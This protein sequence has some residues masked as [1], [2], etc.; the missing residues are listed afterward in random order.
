MDCRQPASPPTVPASCHRCD[1]RLPDHQQHTDRKGQDARV[2]MIRQP[3]GKRY[4]SLL[5]PTNLL[6]DGYLGRFPQ[7]VKRPRCINTHHH[8]K[9]RL[10][11]SGAIP[12]SP[13]RLQRRAKGLY[14]YRATE[15]SSTNFN[16]GI[17]QT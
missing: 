17:T 11:M 3:A 15:V 8:L 10:R 13:I 9:P 6:S 12:P 1:I 16:P 5:G 4:R 2:I 7:G 14:C